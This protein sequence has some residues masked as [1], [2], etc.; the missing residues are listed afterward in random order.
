MINKFFVY[1]TLMRGM[2]NQHFI[3]E[4]AITSIKPVELLGTLYWVERGNYPALRFNSSKEYLIHGELVEIKDEFLKQT[5]ASCDHLEGHP[6]FYKRVIVDVTDMDGKTC[7]AYAYEFQH[8]NMLGDEI[9]N[10]NF[11]D[12]FENKF[13]RHM[14]Y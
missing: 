8:Y 3:S 11:R 1:G 9:P 2:S 5:L 14:A 12:A 7:K 6:S 13:K 10:G 4:K